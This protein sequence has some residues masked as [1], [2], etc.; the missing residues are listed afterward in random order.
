MV[1]KRVAVFFSRA[2]NQIEVEDNTQLSADEYRHLIMHA[3]LSKG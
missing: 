2:Y 1:L 3:C